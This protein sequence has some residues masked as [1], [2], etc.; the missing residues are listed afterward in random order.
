MRGE[1]FFFFNGS[2]NSKDMTKV[3]KRLENAY[4]LSFIAKIVSFN[5]FYI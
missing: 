5:L 3:S 1:V 4:L 2:K